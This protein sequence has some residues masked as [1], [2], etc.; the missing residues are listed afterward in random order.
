[1]KLIQDFKV[2]KIEI[3]NIGKYNYYRDDCMK[4]KLFGHVIH[5]QKEMC[6]DDEIDLHTRKLRKYNKNYVSRAL[7][8]YVIQVINND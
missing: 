3:Y 4:N 6:S 7:K 1:M 2:S 5:F 8:L